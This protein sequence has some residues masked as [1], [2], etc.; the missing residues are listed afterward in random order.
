MK[1][2]G[3][4]YKTDPVLK[5]LTDLDHATLILARRVQA[6]GS[7]IED[8]QD[9]DVHDEGDGVDQGS[10]SD[11]VVSQAE[12]DDTDA[13]PAFSTNSEPPPMEEQREPTATPGFRKK[14][15][16]VGELRAL[17]SFSAPLMG[18]LDDDDDDDDNTPTI[19]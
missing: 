11:M 7:H 17:T 6:R 16:T 2:N 10:V 14:N 12:P 5:R 13:V 9:L 1:P 19:K 15:I 8:I 3:R 18:T 4:D